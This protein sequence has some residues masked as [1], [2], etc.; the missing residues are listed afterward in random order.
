MTSSLS[1]QGAL[2]EAL[3]LYEQWFASAPTHLGSKHLDA[4]REL[5]DRGQAFLEKVSTLFS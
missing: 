2:D 5:L 3:P 4:S 1:L